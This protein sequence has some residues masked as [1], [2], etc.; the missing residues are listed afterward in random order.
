MSG[1]KNNPNW[2]DTFLGGSILVGFVVIAV[3]AAVCTLLSW[4]H[5]R[6]T[7]KL[8]RIDPPHELSRSYFSTNKA[9]G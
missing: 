2:Q 9:P 3:V 4:G 6:A 7:S 5:D 1:D 8:T